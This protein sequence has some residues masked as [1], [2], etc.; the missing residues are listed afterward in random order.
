MLQCLRMWAVTGENRRRIQVSLECDC[1][2]GLFVLNVAFEGSRAL[3]VLM[4]I[5]GVRSCFVHL[6]RV[7]VHPRAAWLDLLC[8]VMASHQ[9]APPQLWP[10]R[11]QVFKHAQPVVAGVHVDEIKRT[12]DEPPRTD[13]RQVGAQHTSSQVAGVH[14]LEQIAVCLS[15]PFTLDVYIGIRTVHVVLKVHPGID[16]YVQRALFPLGENDACELAISGAELHSRAAQANRTKQ[17][18]QIRTVAQRWER[19][20]GTRGSSWRC[21]HRRH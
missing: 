8:V 21:W 19:G 16:L 4:A 7:E 5:L 18:S 13:A 11:V 15:S 1:D 14:S 17:S 12:V 10:P 6:G 9:A 2:S 3:P 20:D